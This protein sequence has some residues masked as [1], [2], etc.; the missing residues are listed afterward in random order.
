MS[1]PWADQPYPLISTPK[2]L[3]TKASAGTLHVSVGMALAHNLMIRY[4]NSI[5]LQA[6]GIT[7]TS[8][9]TDFMF[10][11]QAWC[12]IIHE[13]HTQEE[14]KFFPA[15]EA[16]SGQKG[17]MDG[18]VEEHHSFAAGLEKFEQYVN[19]TKADYYDGKAL[20]AMI[21]DF[22]PALVKHLHA[23]IAMLV[24]VGEAFG[25]DK[26]QTTYDLWESEIV[27]E[28]RAKADPFIMIPGGFG[29]VDH[30]FEDGRHKDWPPHPWFV[31]YLN[32]F[33]FSW[34]HLGAWRFS[35]CENFRKRNL[36]Y[37]GNDWGSSRAFTEKI[38][39]NN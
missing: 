29:A 21:E 15:V 19:N 6:T 38:V 39:I 7:K 8:Y 36:Q 4:L 2:V 32:R 12:G 9:I 33:V 5:Y 35:P 34:K 18:L 28:S 37:V 24:K 30:D 26:L 13:H 27:K 1:V 20:R 10:Y 22:A 25:G 3:G 14:E 31:P 16:Y 23:E 11:C 17:L